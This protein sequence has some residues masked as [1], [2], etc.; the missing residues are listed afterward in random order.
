NI[1]N[2]IITS[3][4]GARVG[5]ALI[6]GGQ[7][8][9]NLGIVSNCVIS[10]NTATMAGYPGG[11]HL[12]QKAIF[13]SEIS[14]NTGPIGGLYS[15]W[16]T[17]AIDNCK[18]IGNQGTDCGGASLNAGY[19][20]K[21]KNCLIYGNHA[22]AGPGGIKISL[23]GYAITYYLRNCVIVSNS[24]ASLTNAGGIYFYTTSGN[25]KE[26][27]ACYNSIVYYNTAGGVNSNVHNNGSSNIF[28]Q[29]G[30]IGMTNGALWPSTNINNVIYADPLFL[31]LPAGNCRLDSK[32]PCINAGYY[33]SWMA[34]GV[35]LDDRI[36]IRYGTVDLGAYEFIRSGAVFGFH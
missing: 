11:L 18:I 13:N 12:Q 33:E 22:T 14:S 7:Y 36:R 10:Y 5:G 23:E 28:I 16:Y 25:P 30:C 19:L 3:N 27:L 20:W 32:S 1:L 21:M 29:N 31:D 8:G 26:S 34:T 6:S 15:G 35:D 4:R 24:T 17:D 2:C 9:G